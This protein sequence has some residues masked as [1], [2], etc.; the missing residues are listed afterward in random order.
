[1]PIKK[2]ARPGC[3]KAVPRRRIKRY[4]EVNTDSFVSVIFGIVG[5]C[6]VAIG[7]IHKYRYIEK[8]NVLR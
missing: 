8:G 4:C 5:A 3:D 6:V 2:R 7:L 1:L